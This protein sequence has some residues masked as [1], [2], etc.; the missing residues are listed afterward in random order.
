M[1]LLT[2]FVRDL[3]LHLAAELVLHYLLKTL[4]NKTWRG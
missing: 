2:E 1:I 4:R 3:L